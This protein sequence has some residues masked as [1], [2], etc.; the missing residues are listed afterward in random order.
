MQLGG[1][2]TPV[3]ERQVKQLLG[4][5]WRDQV[6]LEAGDHQKGPVR[7]QFQ[8]FDQ[9]NF[10]QIRQVASVRVVKLFREALQRF[11]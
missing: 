4:W 3:F 1:E 2:K 6:R 9:K 5:Q 11:G 8:F 7:V 10:G